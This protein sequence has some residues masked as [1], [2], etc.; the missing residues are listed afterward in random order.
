M[1]RSGVLRPHGPLEVS[2]AGCMVELGGF[3]PRPQAFVAQIYM[4]SD[5]I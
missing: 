3:E 4:F 2:L 5:L 1:R